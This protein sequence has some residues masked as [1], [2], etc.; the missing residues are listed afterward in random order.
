MRVRRVVDLSLPLDGGTVVY[1]GDPPV[2][3]ETFDVDSDGFTVSRLSFGSHAGTHAD[4]PLHFV[5]GS[6]PLDEV[7]PSLFVGTGLLVDVRHRGEREEITL[8]DVA[9]SLDAMGPG[10]VVLVQTGWTRHYGSPRYFDHP[11]LTEAA[12]QAIVDRGVRTVGVDALSLDETIDDEHPGAGWP[13]HRVVLG[14][15]GVLLENLAH[16]DDIDFARPLISALPPR[17][18][19]VDG[20]PVRAVALQLTSD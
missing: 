12:C 10:I 8:D 11:Y 4:A 13:C 16:L 3:I 6:T 20:A 5:A 9:A 1:P 2:G 14:A 18:T 17:I 7:D 19:G 15:G